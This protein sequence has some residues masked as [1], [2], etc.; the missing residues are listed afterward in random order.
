MKPFMSYHNLRSLIR[1]GRP[2]RRVAVL[3]VVLASLLIML[4]PLWPK[5]VP[6]SGPARAAP[7]DGPSPPSDVLVMDDAFAPPV[8]TITV[9]STVRWVNRGQALHTTTSDTGLWNWTLVPGA[10]FSATFLTPG[11]YAYHCVYHA[12]S[13]MRG[14][15]IVTRAP[16]PG[17]PIPPPPLPGGE[18]EIVYDYYP[19]AMASTSELFSVR[20]DGSG[21]VQLT[22]TEDLYEAQPRWS[23]DRR[24]IA[25]TA[26][27]G[28]SVL[29]PWRLHLLDPST[30]QSWAITAGPEHYEPDWSP[31][32]ALIAYTS[33]SRSGRQ[34]TRSSIDVVAP[35]G[36]GARTLIALDSTSAALASATWSPDGRAI[37]FTV[38][39]D[40]T[41]GELYVMNA[42]GSQAHRLLAHAGWDD[43][44]AAW[45]PDGNYIAFA[46]GINRGN[47][48]LTT[49]DIWVYDLRR[50]IYGVVAMHSVWDLRRPAWSPDGQHLVFTAQ[51]QGQPSP[52]WALYLVPALG[53]A[54]SGPLTL[55][56]EPDWGS[57]ALV[58]LPTPNPAST[59]TVEPPPPPPLPPAFPTFPPP[60]PT[61]PGPPPTFPPPP[62]PELTPTGEPPVPP[63]T[64]RARVYLTVLNPT[65]S[66]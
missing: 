16:A 62:E 45:S 2:T 37:A 46:S 5:A 61:L 65:S 60:E 11:S 39:S 30:K 57:A 41:G 43:L 26:S 63:I 51:I 22:D 28:A 15:V 17:P 52:R 66:D 54:V 64:V 56:A 12:A 18:G 33:I 7:D 31:D 27:A 53:G 55:G 48:A 36:S 8:I 38:R 13:G 14:Q 1:F 9:G 32:G 23:P 24:L 29:D 40:A 20:P 35:D 4:I 25:Y 42:D 10:R 47:V 6:G 49:H 58:P 44:D 3:V 50:G 34:M 19:E 21:Q 59:A